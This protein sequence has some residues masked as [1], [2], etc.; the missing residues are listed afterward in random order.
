MLPHSTGS[1]GR[2]DEKFSSRMLWVSW[3]W[4][5]RVLGEYLFKSECLQQKAAAAC[6]AP[7]YGLSFCTTCRSKL[8]MVVLVCAP[9]SK[10]CCSSSR[11]V[12]VAVPAVQADADTTELADVS[13]QAY[14]HVLVWL[15]VCPVGCVSCQ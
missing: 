11:G 5:L 12:G 10:R 4:V 1:M 15:F 9:A 3:G 8:G 14:V 7:Y 6:V 2:P 13:M